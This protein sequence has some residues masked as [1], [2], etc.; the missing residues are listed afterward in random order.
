MIN[1]LTYTK[2]LKHNKNP[3]RKFTVPFKKNYYKISRK[4]A[5]LKC[6]NYIK[7]D[8]IRKNNLIPILDKNVF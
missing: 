6:Q 7:L 5:Y 1:R 3:K 4:I 2:E 8:L